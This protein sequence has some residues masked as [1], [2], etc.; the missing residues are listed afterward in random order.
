MGTKNHLPTN[1][2]VISTNDRSTICPCPSA[3]VGWPPILLSNFLCLS[4]SVASKP[5][6]VA[7]LCES[8]TYACSSHMIRV[9]FGIAPIDLL[10]V[11]GSWT[12]YTV[13]AIF[14]YAVDLQSREIVRFHAIN[15]IIHLR[16]RVKERDGIKRKREANLHVEWKMILED[17]VLLIPS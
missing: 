9:T 12:A 11:M 16:M 14:P 4:S 17:R 1:P 5:G 10:E 15:E 3:I 8:S 13:S 2:T 7:C 6:F